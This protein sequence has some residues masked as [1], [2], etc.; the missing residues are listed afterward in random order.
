MRHKSLTNSRKRTDPTFRH[1]YFLES[2]FDEV[3]FWTGWSIT[4]GGPVEH[5]RGI[6]QNADDPHHI[7]HI[8]QKRDWRTNLCNLPREAHDTIHFGIRGEPQWGTLLCIVAKLRKQEKTDDP[9][10]FDLPLLDD[11]LGK[12]VI[13][14]IEG[15]DLHDWAEPFRDEALSRLSQ[16]ASA[17]RKEGA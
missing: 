9:D 16:L 4:G 14:T 11:C 17:E 13:A 3:L 2:P 7:C 8:G 6:V 12:S 15:Y 1:A 5:W 10:E